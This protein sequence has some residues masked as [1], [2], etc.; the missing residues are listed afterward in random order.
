MAAGDASN[1]EALAALP[2][3]PENP[4]LTRKNRLRR[5]RW[6]LAHG[7][8]ESATT[9]QRPLAAGQ[10]EVAQVNRGVTYDFG[11]AGRKPSPP[12]TNRPLWT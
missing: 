9:E 7:G 10:P 6:L 5:A 11:K 12:Q 3:S 8:M 2:P 1:A 4:F